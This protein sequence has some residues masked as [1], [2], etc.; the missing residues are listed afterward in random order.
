MAG[1]SEMVIL[2]ADDWIC[3]FVLFVVCTRL[4]AQGANGGWVMPGLVF[5]WFSLW[6]FSYLIVPRVGSSV[7]I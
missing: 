7:A 6:E 3:I 5:K 1:L 4:P 2:S